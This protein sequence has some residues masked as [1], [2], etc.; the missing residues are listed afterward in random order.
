[1]LDRHQVDDI[2]NNMIEDINYIKISIYQNRELN[3]QIL[4]FLR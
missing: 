2:I 4:I 3:W 1:M